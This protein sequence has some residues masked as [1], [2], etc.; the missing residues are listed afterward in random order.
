[1]EHILA[2]QMLDVSL[3]AEDSCTSTVSCDSHASCVSTQSSA[4]GQFA[5]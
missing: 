2:M 1:M 4:I 5:F 3:S